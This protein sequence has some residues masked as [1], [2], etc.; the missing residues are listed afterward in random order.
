MSPTS[1]FGLT[2]VVIAVGLATG[3]V[4]AEAAP[5]LLVGRP[6]VEATSS[7]AAIVRGT[8]APAKRR[9]AYH[10]VYRRPGGAWTR[11][12]RRVAQV[13]RRRT[14]TVPVTGLTPGTDYAVR[15]VATTCGGCRS[16]TSRGRERSFRTRPQPTP[17]PPAPPPASAPTPAPAVASVAAVPVEPAPTRTPE[18]APAPQ[19]APAPAPE[20]PAGSY[21]NPVSGPGEFPDPTVIRAGSSYYAYATG[22][23]FQV[24]RSADLVHWERLAPALDARPDWAVTDPDWHP[25]A[26]SVLPTSGPCPGATTGG[27]YLLFHVALSRKFGS[28]VTNCIGVAASRTPQGPF[29]DRGPLE[30]ADGTREDGWPIGC[31]DRAGHGNI[32]PQPF[33]DDD[34]KAWLYV[35]TDF[36]C[37]DAPQTC[38]LLPEIS[39]I[40]LATDLVHAAG[41][42]QPLLAGQAGTW[43]QAPWAPV[44][45]NPWIVKRGDTYHLLYSGGSWQDRY[46]MGHATATSP[47]GPFT[48]TAASP[49]TQGTDAVKSVGGGMVISDAAGAEWLA[50]HGRDRYA[51]PTVPRTLRIDPL[52]WSDERPGL[53]GPST[54]TRVA[55]TP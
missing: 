17:T 46:G 23:R 16:G 12:P 36:T 31:G 53:N 33:V 18:P 25:W 4:A 6:S 52:V 55:P 50:Y 20:P 54:D 40:P 21:R 7:H 47:T 19:P 41:A 49:W 48:R 9:V 37:P 45:E 2:L 39:V 32:D 42:R 28:A 43:E 26:P 51:D 15:F 10:V 34:G 27:C 1:R 14:V 38:R 8:L 24:M 29:T 44:V 11:T 22:D 3:P 30:Q 13:R 5:D 35:S